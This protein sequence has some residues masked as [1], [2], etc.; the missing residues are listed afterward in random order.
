MQ[1]KQREHDKLVKR[2]NINKNWMNQ[3]FASVGKCSPHILWVR[4]HKGVI[5]L[6][7]TLL[8]SSKVKH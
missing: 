8:D 3:D 1:L 4:M 7:H 5:S 2:P 6:E